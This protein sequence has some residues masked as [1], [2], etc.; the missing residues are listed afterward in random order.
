MKERSFLTESSKFEEAD[1]VI[2]GVPLGKDAKKIL[3]SLRETS[4]FVEFFDVDKKRNLIE[5]VKFYD[6]GDV[7]LT[8]ENDIVVKTKEILESK[9]IP[10]ILGKSHLLTLFALRAFD[11][12]KVVSFD[13]HADIKNEYYDEKIS[14]STEP[15]RIKEQARYNCTTWLRRAFEEGKKDIAIVG[16]RSCDEDDFSFIEKN[17]ILAFSPNKI[18]KDFYE[19]KRIKENLK[20][21]VRDSKVYLSIDIDVFDPS[22]APAVEHPEP[23]G[24]LLPEFLELLEIFKGKIVGFDLVEIAFCEKKLMEITEFLAT[25]VILEVLSRIK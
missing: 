7:Q 4:W 9:K 3:T 24:L 10:L 5:K 23:N 14:Q 15:L 16:L 12:V 13:A 22:I 18:K 8:S 1:I 2:F 20:K 19:K 21:F 17:K 25:R 11:N 6:A